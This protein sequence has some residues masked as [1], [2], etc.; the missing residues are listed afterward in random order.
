[1][2]R[3]VVV[4]LLLIANAIF[5]SSKIKIADEAPAAAKVAQASSVQ[6]PPENKLGVCATL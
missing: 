4:L 6:S 3:A 1:M 2:K 5:G